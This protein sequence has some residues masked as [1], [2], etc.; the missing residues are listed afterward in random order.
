MV[1]GRWVR[2][3]ANEACLLPPFTANAIQAVR[4]ESVW[5]F[6]WVR[7]LESPVQNPLVSAKSPVK[8]VFAAAALLHAVKGLHAEA[9]E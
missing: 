7:Y 2:V 4:G 9:S 3:G 5:K 8:G 6:C 1:D